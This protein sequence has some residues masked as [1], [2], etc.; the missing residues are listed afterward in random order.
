[1]S[2]KLIYCSKFAAK[3]ENGR[4]NW[5]DQFLK[6]GPF[7]KRVGLSRTKVYVKLLVSRGQIL[8][9]AGLYRLKMINARAGAYHLESIKKGQA[10]RD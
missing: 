4:K 3:H 2:L 7:L 8:F 9:R 5:A 10:T 1:M 6:P